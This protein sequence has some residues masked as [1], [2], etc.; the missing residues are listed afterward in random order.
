[1]SK[2]STNQ[3]TLDLLPLESET[4]FLIEPGVATATFFKASSF[5]E[6]S[7]WLKEKYVKVLTANPW[8]A[9]RLIRPKG[10]KQVQLTYP[11]ALTDHHINELFHIQALQINSTT[12]YATIYKTLTKN[13]A[14]HIGPGLKLLN[15]DKPLASLAISQTN[16]DEF[17][18]VFSVS[19]IIGDGA[20]YYTL[21]NMILSDE[22]VV[23]L[24]PKRDE[25]YSTEKAMGKKDYRYLVGKLRTIKELFC[26]VFGPKS[27]VIAYTIN[28]QA[29][30]DTKAK[31]PKTAQVPFISTNDIICSGFMRAIKS[32]LCLMA[33]N[34]R[35]RYGK[36]NNQHAGNYEGVV[37][38]DQPVYQ[39]PEGI[40]Q[41]L[42]GD[43]PLTSH[44]NPLPNTLETFSSRGGII[45]NWSS[46]AKDFKINQ[47]YYDLHIPL[48]PL[49]LPSDAMVIFKCRPNTL[50]IMILS[51]YHSFDYFVNNPQNPLSQ[52]LDQPISTA[53]FGQSAKS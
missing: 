3:I 46:F 30:A 9:G 28:D 49:S 7:S 44:A 50:A 12:P 5:D 6:A 22:A 52:Y 26:W 35:G 19:H 38:Y 1:M 23:A 4:A 47:T 8:L 34:Y 42:Q 40:R 37:F 29:I 24:N 53:I 39:T 27:K 41:S 16:Q 2:Q 10:H 36:L 21:L 14:T 43:L 51:K 17:M 31:L 13:P 20:T 25:S 32:R 15:K 18:V 11:Q 45:T 33:I 48:L